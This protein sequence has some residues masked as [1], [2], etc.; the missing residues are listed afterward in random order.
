MMTF[1]IHEQKVNEQ[2]EWVKGEYKVY[3]RTFRTLTELVDTIDSEW[4]WA[5]VE[6]STLFGND[7]WLRRNESLDSEAWND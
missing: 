4:D 3:E 1:K 6:I 7:I 2:G 5:K